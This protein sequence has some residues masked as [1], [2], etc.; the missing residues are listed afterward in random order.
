MNTVLKAKNSFQDGMLLDF[1]PTNTQATCL[2]SALNATLI[3]NNGNEMSLQNDMGN[4]RVETAYLP[5]GY[6]PVGTCEYGDI[7][8]II[9]YNPL[10]DKAQIGCFPSPERNISTEELSDLEVVLSASDFQ[11][12]DKNQP[13]GKLK[14]M[15]I[16]KELTQFNLQAGDKFI[17][18]SSNI[19]KQASSI[20][21][22]GAKSC[23]NDDFPQLVKIHVVSV[24]DDGKITYLDSSV[25]WYDRSKN[26]PYFVATLKDDK[27]TEVLDIDSYRT[28]LSSGY[29]V[30]SSKVSG[31]LALLIE[32]ETISGFNCSWD[33]YKV[34]ETQ[35]ELDQYGNILNNDQE[36]P[37]GVATHTVIKSDYLVDLFVSWT[38]DNPD[39]NPLGVQFKTNYDPESE[40]KHYSIWKLNDSDVLEK[41]NIPIPAITTDYFYKPEDN[42]SSKYKEL[43]KNGYYDFSYLDK[44]DYSNWE[45]NNY[46]KVL[47]DFKSVNKI[48]HQYQIQ[49]K[50]TYIEGEISYDETITH[51]LPYPIIDITSG[52]SVF[53][54]ENGE[55]IENLYD[56]II[57]NYYKKPIPIRVGKFSLYTDTICKMT[58]NVLKKKAENEGEQ[59]EY[60]KIVVSEKKLSNDLSEAI[61]E[62][63]VI[64][65]MEYGFLD[66]LKV[67]NIIDFS[68]VGK[69]Y[70]NLNTWKYYN[71][72]TNSTLIWG[73]EMYT[74]PNE[75]VSNVVFNFYSNNGLCYT[76]EHKDFP[77][78][79]GQ[80]TDHIIIS[81]DENQTEGI[82][83]KNPLYLVEIII[84]YKYKNSGISKDT[85]TKFYRWFWSNDIFNN[86]FTITNDFDLLNPSICQQFSVNFNATDLGK[87][88]EAKIHNNY[89]QQQYT[90]NITLELRKL[91]SYF[92]YDDYDYEVY[93]N[94]EDM[95]TEAKYED[96]P[97]ITIKYI[98]EYEDN[99]FN[100]DR[101]IFDV[102]N[103]GGTTVITKEPIH[104]KDQEKDQE[105]DLFEYVNRDGKR[106]NL[107][108][109]VNKRK[110]I[111]DF[112]LKFDKPIRSYFEAKLND[113]GT[114]LPVYNSYIYND[115]NLSKYNLQKFDIGINFIFYEFAGMYNVEDEG[116]DRRDHW[117]SQ[118]G[119]F[120]RV[121][122][123]TGWASRVRQSSWM[124]RI[125][126]M[127]KDDYGYKD[128]L[129]EL[130]YIVEGNFVPFVMGFSD[131][132]ISE[133]EV[134]YLANSYT[135]DT[136]LV[137]DFELGGY[138][139]W[140]GAQSKKLDRQG[141]FNDN[142]HVCLIFKTPEN[143]ITNNVMSHNE[144]LNQYVTLLDSL[145]Y[146]TSETVLIGGTK[147]ENVAYLSEF[148]FVYI[149][150]V[151]VRI[152]NSKENPNIKI[153]GNYIEQLINNIL[154][155]AGIE[156]FEK[157]SIN[158]NNTIFNI[159][160]FVCN[161]P[162]KIRIPYFQE[163]DVNKYIGIIKG[164]S[165]D[166][167]IKGYVRNRRNK[168]GHP[169]KFNDKSMGNTT[170]NNFYF[171]SGNDDDPLMSNNEDA[172]TDSNQV[173]A[174]YDWTK[175]DPEDTGKLLQ[176]HDTLL[177]SLKNS[178]NKLIIGSKID[179]TASDYDYIHMTNTAGG[180]YKTGIKFPQHNFLVTPK[181]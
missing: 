72:S 119:Y 39:V 167:N 20:S 109:Q 29:S 145:Y 47:D 154:K 11:E 146:K 46:Y 73:F 105:S 96:Q 141:T 152:T 49:E 44:S 147:V 48:N 63:D 25:K 148:Y 95:T 83:S 19:N 172:L 126:V 74:N 53:V 174:L 37:E 68:K 6:V 35:V 138:K 9:S 180:T 85:V 115:S 61:Y 65:Y 176:I 79:N 101:K 33:I 122:N 56:D 170:S 71:Q 58:K 75:I 168:D 102:Y 59:D 120:K 117:S 144:C 149:S 84:H 64:P 8:Y 50:K 159:L 106:V 13:T 15:S 125:S 179:S 2:T 165:I 26:T 163:N 4:G 110:S 123:G 22:F 67:H 80:F 155:V 77:S 7:I 143:V 98:D 23:N 14:T 124:S 78:Y 88:F 137:V 116:K 160:P 103:E 142:K 1:S 158:L 62:F 157:E 112:T 140:G 151:I 127:F 66:N 89:W 99:K 41:I 118:R 133:P 162:L 54:D 43:V 139:K 94:N 129:G 70:I 12:L 86:N 97:N 52:R 111:Q 81:N 177:K 60:E 156:E 82:T 57:N 175:K 169:V 34:G 178:N 107:S 161:F 5:D 131:A 40:S 27:Q 31:K 18:A 76:I 173:C 10:I 55:V 32:L 24:A 166:S 87:A 171:W 93:V 104:E 128:I 153:N 21:A 150:D 38:T 130:P 28:M 164:D 135:P 16:K 132:L 36:Q 91:D 121:D 92:D 3:T 17:I 69:E 113:E 114:E 45:Q 181:Q 42:S 100:V 108:V 30:Y 136:A 51:N 90:S 134:K